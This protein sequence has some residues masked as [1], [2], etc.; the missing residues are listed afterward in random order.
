[1]S[2]Y[3]PKLSGSFIV[4]RGSYSKPKDQEQL[5]VED[6]KQNNPHSDITSD[7]SNVPPLNNV[8][9]NGAEKDGKS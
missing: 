2:V 6:G 1:M 3:Q 5:K 7:I 8:V 9:Q 4:S